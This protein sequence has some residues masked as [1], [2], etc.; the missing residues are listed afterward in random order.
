M[1]IP[2]VD[3]GPTVTTGAMVGALFGA[4][5]PPLRPPVEAPFGS[6]GGAPPAG[7]AAAP[8]PATGPPSKLAPATAPIEEPPL[9][10][11]A[12][13]APSVGSNG[14]YRISKKPKK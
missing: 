6:R 8:L 10:R 9:K 13:D 4:S 3:K 2:Q 5:T 7:A 12:S 14:R 1:T 11:N